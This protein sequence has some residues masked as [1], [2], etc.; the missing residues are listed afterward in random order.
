MLKPVSHHFPWDEAEDVAFCG[1]R[2][3]DGDVHSP[4]P[5]CPICRARLE[6]EDALDDA[7]AQT[8]LPLDADEA[9]AILDPVLNAGVPVR[10]P[11][12]PFGASLFALAVALNRTYAE[13]AQLARRRGGR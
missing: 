3:Q 7:I 1:R 8:P 13:Q 2:Q 11:L 9:A 6:A 4:S 12:S 5:T 10:A